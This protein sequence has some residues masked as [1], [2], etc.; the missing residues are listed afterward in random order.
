MWM[1]QHLQNRLSVACLAQKWCSSSFEPAV[2]TCDAVLSVLK[3]ILLLAGQ[4]VCLFRTLLMYHWFLPRSCVP[5]KRFVAR[6]RS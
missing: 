4:T 5:E 3:D 1:R 2:C 6:N